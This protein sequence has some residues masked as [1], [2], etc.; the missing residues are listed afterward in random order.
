MA[1]TFNASTQYGSVAT[2]TNYNPTDVTISVWVYVDSTYA[3][4]SGGGIRIIEIG[5]Y[6]G[7]ASILD[8]LAIEYNANND[9][10]AGVVWEDSNWTTT[11]GSSVSVDF[12]QWNHL[13]IT[14]RLTTS[15]LNRFFYNG[16]KQGSDTTSG[17]RSASTQ[18]IGVAT[19]NQ[20]N[21]SDLFEGYIAEIAIFDTNLSDAN[22]ALLAAGDS[23]VAVDEAN[24]VA[25]WR[26]DGS[27]STASDY[28]ASATLTYT[29]S[30]GSTT[31][32]TVDDP[33]ATGSALPL[34]N[35]YYS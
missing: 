2:S 19:N 5:G 15:E 34:L 29:G 21:G 10:I 9:T 3:T 33:P 1:R 17:G 28:V 6:D 16:V 7:A 26:M 30:P 24:L 35:A 22:V 14:A 23:P 32:P 31:G 18:S 13:A 4:M 12:D 20:S 27:G 11:I 25:Y 8:G